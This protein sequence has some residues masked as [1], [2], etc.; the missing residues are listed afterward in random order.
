[1]RGEGGGQGERRGHP[2]GGR[3]RPVLQLFEPEP[4]AC[5]AGAS[6]E[7]H[8]KPFPNGMRDVRSGK[9]VN[10]YESA[11]R[12]PVAGS[13]T[14]SGKASRARRGDP[15]ASYGGGFLGGRVFGKCEPI[16]RAKD[17]KAR[18]CCKP[19]GGG[20]KGVLGFFS[21][22]RKPGCRNGTGR[23]IPRWNG[24][25][26]SPTVAVSRRGSPHVGVGVA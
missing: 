10:Q 21:P 1:D 8:R 18:P 9:R 12:Q 14:R 17:S 23:P 5:G 3:R 13:A 2:Q 4:G 6:R 22:R 16:T 26:G 24:P 7:L 11:R 25:A 15:R 19:P 20:R